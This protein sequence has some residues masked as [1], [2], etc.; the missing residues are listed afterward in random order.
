MKVSANHHVTN[1]MAM[2]PLSVTTIRSLL[3]QLTIMETFRGAVQNGVFQTARKKISDKCSFTQN[4]KLH[5]WPRIMCFWFLISLIITYSMSVGSMHAYKIFPYISDTGTYPPE[6]CIFGQ[7]INLGTLLMVLN[8][9]LR[10]RQVG[11][12]S[13]LHDIECSKLNSSSM[14]CAMIGCLGLSIVA[15]FQKTNMRGIHFLGA[16]MV[17]GGGVLYTI[18]QTQISYS[19]RNLETKPNH[20]GISIKTIILRIIITILCVILFF[21]LIFC[22]YASEKDYEGDLIWWTPNDSGYIPHIFATI[23]EWLIII[24]ISVFL[25]SYTNEFKS[26]S[27]V[28]IDIEIK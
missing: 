13:K 28:G 6:S 8:M 2:N 4:F 23:S 1:V 9:Y 15:N 24:L 19:F 16:D 27:Y 14:W 21:I 18:L 3:T 10:Y 12:V 11:L 7:L 25:L 20:C 22:G 17:L 5:Y 26:L